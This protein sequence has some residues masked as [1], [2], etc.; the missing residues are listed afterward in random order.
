MQTKH[1]HAHR[2]FFVGSICQLASC[3]FE[4]VIRLSGRLVSVYS[5]A[6]TGLKLNAS[7]FVQQLCQVPMLQ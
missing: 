4:V 3:G 1:T 6:E 5:L 2:S 7:L